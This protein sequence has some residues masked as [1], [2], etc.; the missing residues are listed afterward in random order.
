LDTKAPAKILLTR[1]GSVCGA[2]L[3]YNLNGVFNYLHIGWWLSARGF[4][5]GVRVRPRE[6]LFR[7]I[8]GGIAEPKVLYLEFGVA[9]GASLRQWSKLLRSQTDLLQET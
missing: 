2:R 6:Q 3:I 9:K 8:A 4:R 1:L 7:H 5:P